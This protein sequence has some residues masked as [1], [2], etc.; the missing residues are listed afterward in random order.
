MTVN[1]T[2][3]LLAVD[4]DLPATFRT[5]AQRWRSETGHLSIIQQKVMIGTS[6]RETDRMARTCFASAIGAGGHPTGTQAEQS[7]ELAWTPGPEALSGAMAPEQGRR[8][9]TRAG[10]AASSRVHAR[11]AAISRTLPA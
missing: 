7:G 2:N 10:A 3:P 1:R 5:L 8:R 4:V 6:G 9:A 11:S